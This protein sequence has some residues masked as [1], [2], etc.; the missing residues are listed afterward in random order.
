MLKLIFWIAIL[1][2]ALSFFG[3]SVQ[4]IIGSPAG[5]EN[6]TYVLR[7]LSQGWQWIVAKV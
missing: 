3:I 2:L 4:A 6:V 5:Q 1:V 7:L